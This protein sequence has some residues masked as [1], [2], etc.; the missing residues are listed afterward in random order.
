MGV[1]FRQFPSPVKVIIAKN[2]S[3]TIVFLHEKSARSVS[4]L[5]KWLCNASTTW[6]AIKGHYGST[7]STP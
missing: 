7:G 6:L 5:L 1:L 4:S 2:G 3:V